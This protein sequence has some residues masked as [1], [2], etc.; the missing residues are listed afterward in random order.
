MKATR[1]SSG[2]ETA[3][4]FQVLLSIFVVAV[5]VNY[6]WERAQSWL[7]MRLDGSAIPAWM[8]VIASL[9][10]GSLVL[11]IY[12][13]GYAVVQRRNWFEYPGAY[14]YTVMFVLGFVIGVTVEWA[15]MSV[16]S[17]WV[18]RVQM[19]LLPGLGVGVVPVAQMLVLPP[20]I[21]RLVAAWRRRTWNITIGTVIEI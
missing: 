10:D 5:L 8:C 16:M 1:F 21:F 11:V 14:G 18:Y 12:G 9:V 7:Y 13:A 15:T 20:L 17:R 4:L 6:P 19:P 2:H 3:S